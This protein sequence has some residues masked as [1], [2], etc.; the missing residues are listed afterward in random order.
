MKLLGL[1]LCD[2]D[3]NITL[4]DGGD[5]QYY[6][7]ERDTQEKHQAFKNL[8]E[9]EHTL[10]KKFNIHVSEIDEIAIVLDPWNY[11][12]CSDLNTKPKFPA[13]EINIFPNVKCK[14]WWLNHHYAHA[15]S[16][17]IILKEKLDLHLV[18]DGFGDQNISWT[19]FKNDEIVDIGLFD[20]DGS[21]GRQYEDLAKHLNVGGHAYDLSGKLMGLQSYG[22]LDQKFYDSNK[23]TNL[24]EIT[25]PKKWIE[26]NSNSLLVAENRK[27]DWAKTCHHL[28]YLRLL[29]IF[30]R[31]AKPNDK[32]GYSGG[33]ALNVCWNSGLKNKYKNL[34]V[35][36]HCADD[37][38]SLG[39]VE[40]LRKKKQIIRTKFI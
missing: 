11:K 9:W 32:I 12:I 13:E 23:D 27:L 25:D 35:L 22:N 39:C 29:K 2:H 10:K 31:Y 36:P 21:F 1:R 30:E 6:K 5:I 14:V 38:L 17:D 7:L 26:R 3:S 16:Y 4:Y 19:I 18:V 40:W 33:V 20:R 24:S 15:L 37:G 28:M 34:K 8:W